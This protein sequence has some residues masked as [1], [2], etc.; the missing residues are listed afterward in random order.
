ML[1]GN[2]LEK[3]LAGDG[4][5]SVGLD[6][7]TLALDDP[8]EEPKQDDGIEEVVTPGA[9]A[10]LS[11][12]ENSKS[13]TMKAAAG[14]SQQEPLDLCNGSVKFTYIKKSDVRGQRLG[15]DITIGYRVAEGEPLQEAVV[16]GSK[17]P[18]A[19]EVAVK[20]MQVGETVEVQACG[21][22]ALA[23]EE[24]LAPD[25]CKKT[26]Q[27]ELVTTSGDSRDKFSMSAD[28]RI[29]RA[30]ELRELGTAMLK[31]GRLLRAADYYERGSQLMD[32]IEAEDM[33]VPG[34]KNAAAVETN[35]RIRECQKPLLLNW[36]LVL[37][38]REQ[39]A[40]A[41]QK[42]TEVLLDI[43][44][45]CV[46]ALFR[47]G[48]CRVHLGNLEEA[49]LDL[50]RAQELDQSIA[51]DVEKELHKL[52][53]KQK[54]QDVKDKGW[55]KKAFQ[56]GLGDAR[57]TQAKEVPKKTDQEP[58]EDNEGI[59]CHVKETSAARINHN[60]GQE[61]PEGSHPLLSM[62]KA[63]E[64]A[65]EAGGLHDTDVDWC[66]QREAIYNQFCTRAVNND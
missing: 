45:L 26:F 55:A 50:R 6:D 40:E 63:Q 57:V 11:A 31:R 36:S 51:G 2:D 49:R 4:L 58:A 52:A 14:T 61:L 35:R 16:G 28:E 48:Q 62:L 32:I 27:F 30:N 20:R 47:R 15:D 65:A 42:C 19:L 59:Q 25:H 38:R 9:A 33:G 44:K 54:V 56:K 7:P 18:W 37:K 24:D 1:S 13:N 64:K 22:H 17:L 39:W 8:D 60:K 5:D 66:R 34:K 10:S 23:D 12:E 46:K 3:I 21:E 29:D 41:E 43:D 53:Q